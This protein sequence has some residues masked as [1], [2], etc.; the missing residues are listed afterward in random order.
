MGSL[1]QIDEMMYLC[2]FPDLDGCIVIILRILSVCR[3]Y[4]IELLTS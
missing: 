4:T 1:N 2:Q 3:Q